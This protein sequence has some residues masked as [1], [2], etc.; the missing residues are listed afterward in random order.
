MSSLIFDSKIYGSAWADDDFRA[1]FDEPAMVTDW[2]EILSVLAETQA[3]FDLIPKDAAL[4]IAETCRA[5]VVDGDFLD[6]VGVGFKDSGHSTQGLILAIFRRCP[7]GAGE[8]FYY[9]TT[10]QDL[11]DT[12]MSRAI[13]K[14]HVLIQ[15]SL[16]KILAILLPMANQYKN[17]TMAGR[18][19]GQQ[20]LPITFGFKVANWAGEM[21]RHSERLSEIRPRL[22]YG[23][24]SG[25]VGSMA[26]QGSRGFEIQKMFFDTL[27]LL[28]AP[29]SW[30]SSRDVVAEWSQ[31]LVLI[32]GTA[33]RI[34]H[35]IYN[36]QR[37]EIGEVREGFIEGTVGSITMPH[38]RNPEISEHLGTLSR[39]VRH[40][41]ALICEGLVHEHERD[42]RSWKAEWNAV[43]QATMAAGK[44]M[45]LLAGLVQNLEVDP[46]RMLANLEIT[47]GFVLSEPLMLALA[48][49]VGRKTAHEIIYE[50][51]LKAQEA[52]MSFKEAV[53]SNCDITTHLPNLEMEGF[54]NYAQHTDYCAAM[55]ERFLNEKGGK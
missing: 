10:V 9:G 31:L 15:Q 47:K 7:E 36:L 26:S 19:H 53:L 39:I 2:L 28:P 51:S 45:S 41:A 17:T 12:W 13:L 40:N 1:I 3:H 43:P 8:W 49:K 5:T 4:A 29:V 42:G 54:F 22:M 48:A 35:E 32:C 14:S 38:K 34:G 25:G 27:N 33:D 16:D 44:T 11:T 6:E 18:T 30:T 23:Q 20:G 24:L 46:N 21:A 37:S 55:V 50:M 52:G